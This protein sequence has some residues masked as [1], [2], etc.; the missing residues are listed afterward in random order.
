MKHPFDR[1]LKDTADL[2]MRL[3]V[4]SDTCNSHFGLGANGRGRAPF[5]G[6]MPSLKAVVSGSLSWARRS[7]VARR[8]GR[9]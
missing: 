5:E 4:M 6:K 8:G 3:G 9:R 1:T 7:P 2:A